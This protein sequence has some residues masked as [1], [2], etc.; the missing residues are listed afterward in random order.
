MDRNL[1]SSFSSRWINELLRR[2]KIRPHKNKYWLTSKDRTDP[3]FGQRVAAVCDAY[4][5]AVHDYE[6]HGVHT[7]CIDEQTGIQALERI[8]PDRL[9]L[10]GKV[11][12]RE[13][14]YHRH[15][16]LCLFGNFHVATGKILEPMLRQ[17]RTEEDFLENIDQLIVKDPAANYRFITDNLNTHSSESLVRY[18]ADACGIEEPL[19]VKGEHGIL[20]S[21]RSR[22]AFL[23]DPTHRIRFIYTPR[24]CSWLNQ[25]EIW[26][27]TLRK[28]VT[29]WMSFDSVE[30]LE[31]S[32][33]S[34][35]EYYNKTHAK[36][37][38]WTYTGR[39]L[40]A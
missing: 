26:F 37:Y 38:Q 5:V 11:A 25:I 6:Q 4:L 15:G 27:G 20:E 1:I 22:A 40:A 32:I 23:S 36:P 33:L 8:C 29:R 17:T 21:V 19:G 28:K 39:V 35:I 2:A 34:F 9:V 16:T 7:I 14:E 12:L 3:D 31:A 30:A 18:V 13:Y 10:P 24:H